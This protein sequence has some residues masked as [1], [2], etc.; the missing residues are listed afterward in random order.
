MRG[1]TAAQTFSRKRG[2]IGDPEGGGRQK[3]LRLFF[4]FKFDESTR[5]LLRRGVNWTLM[6]GI[7]FVMHHSTSC[8]Q[9]SGVFGGAWMLYN[10]YLWM[11]PAIQVKNSP[12]QLHQVKWTLWILED[13]SPHQCKIFSDSHQSEKRPQEIHT[14]AQLIYSELCWIQ[15]SITKPLIWVKTRFNWKVNVLSLDPMV[16]ALKSKGVKSQAS[17][18]NRT[19]HVTEV[20]A[21]ARTKTLL[22]LGVVPTVLLF[23]NTSAY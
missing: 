22:T 7:S 16:E 8:V 9:V 5:K 13:V 10:R 19:L 6:S 17:T 14:E 12:L 11:L 4:F 18:L 21:L 3:L 23:L 2:T 1:E 15:V 20:M